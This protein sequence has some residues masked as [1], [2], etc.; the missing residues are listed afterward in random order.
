M[1]YGGLEKER[2]PIV[3]AYWKD[4]K[5]M[6]F[7][8]DTFGTIS[9]EYPKIYSYSREQVDTVI[10]NTRHTISNTD[11]HFMKFLEKKGFVGNEHVAHTLTTEDTLRSWGKFELRVHPFIDRNSASDDIL[12]KVAID[13]LKAPIEIHKFQVLD[14]EN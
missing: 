14:N 11:S 13:N 5:L 10:N 9:M 3:F 7:R 1:T 12:R 2:L 8:A 6:G 4:D